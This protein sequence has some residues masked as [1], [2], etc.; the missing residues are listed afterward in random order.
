MLVDLLVHLAV[1]VEQLAEELD[2][3]VALVVSGQLQVQTQTT[4]EMVAVEQEQS[5]GLITAS[6]VQ[7]TP[8]P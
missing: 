6:Q 7:S 1:V 3:M 8:Q 4:A 5:L 2:K